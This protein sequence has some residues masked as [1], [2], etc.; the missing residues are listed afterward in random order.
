MIEFLIGFIVVVVAFWLAMWV[1][2]FIS[3][4]LWPVWDWIRDLGRY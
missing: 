2:A 1:F 4:L 3:L